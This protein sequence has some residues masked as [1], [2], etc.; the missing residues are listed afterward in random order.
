MATINGVDTSTATAI[1]VGTPLT[2]VLTTTSEHDLFS[3]TLQA[4]VAYDLGLI[5]DATAGGGLGAISDTYLR[6]YDSSG[7]FITYNDDDFSGS[8]FQSFIN[9][10]TVA[11]SGTY[12]LDVASYNGYYNGG[13]RLSVS[14]DTNAPPTLTGT[15]ASMPVATIGQTYFISQTNLLQGYTDPNTGDTLTIQGTPTVSSGSIAATSGG[16]NVTGLTTAGAVTVS[17][18]V[19][20]SHTT[21]AGSTGFTVSS[22]TNTLSLTRMGGN[23]TTEDGGIVTYQIAANNAIT[24]GAI[25]V[26]VT[27][28]DV[29]EGKIVQADGSLG[30]S[31][32]YTLN[33]TTSSATVQVK[34]QQDYSADGT[35]AYQVWMRASDSAS[36]AS[37]AGGTVWGST[38]RDFNGGSALTSYKQETLYNAP[39]VDSVSGRD[40][41]LSLYLIGDNGRPAED[42][43]VGLDGEDRLYGGYMMDSLSGGIGQDRLYGG[44]EDDTLFGG[45]GNDKLYGEQDDDRLFGGLGND[46]MD[47]GLG[48]DRLEGGAGSDTYYLTL[49]DDGE[50]EDEVIESLTDTGTDTVWIPFQVASYTL[51]PGVENVRMNAGFSDTELIGNTA[52]NL[53]TGNAG[54]N[55]ISGGGGNDNIDGGRGND[56]VAGGSGSDTVTGGP[57]QDTLSGG[58]GQD[59][60]VI[61]ETGS[62]N[63]D[64]ILDFIAADDQIGLSASIVP[65]VGASVGS[66]EFSNQTSSVAGTSGVRLI[67]NRSNGLLYYDADGSATTRS[68]TAIANLGAGLPIEYR[69]FYII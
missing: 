45:E 52:N 2:G 14:G 6:V 58:S 1:T 43:L 5:G 3:I 54:N 16:W 8:G 48:A 32:T 60:F 21:V 64:T 66:S 33:S 44:Y 41:D 17:F 10:L 15:P 69:D 20:D 62:A 13:Y 57:G 53:M 51:T 30:E 18:N 38:I 46:I 59:N 11:T 61:S 65:A 25:Q 24:A 28:K 31:R 4:G 40:R 35:V 67:Y 37:S 36:P 23:E 47:G 9:D 56:E 26:T 19:S 50:I 39:D 55:P 29:S 34:G 68:P 49:D 22:A 42:N 7:T 12:Y 63:R 27:S